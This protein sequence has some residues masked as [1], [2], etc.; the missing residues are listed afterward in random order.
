MV[1]RCRTTRMA[2]SLRTASSIP[3]RA[4]C[5]MHASTPTSGNVLQVG[6]GGGLHEPSESHAPFR[7]RIGFGVT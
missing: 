3:T 2:T 4:S 7:L 6:V 1:I 5:H